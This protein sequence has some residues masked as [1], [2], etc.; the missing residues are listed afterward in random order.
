MAAIGRVGV[1]R[2]GQ[3]INRVDDYVIRGHISNLPCRVL[4]LQDIGREG[5]CIQTI[6]IGAQ[7][8]GI[9][10]GHCTRR[11]LGRSTLNS[12]KGGRRGG[13]G[14]TTGDDACGSHGGIEELIDCIA[15]IIGLILTLAWLVPETELLRYRGEDPED[16]EGAR[17][18]GTFH[19]SLANNE[20]LS[21]S[22][23]G[24]NRGITRACLG[25]CKDLPL[26]QGSL[27]FV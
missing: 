4:K 27:L 16:Q 9:A 5:G 2:S 15:R 1:V 20:G 8:D 25:R 26:G 12:R 7:G 3:R 22:V 18:A 6:K 21:Y 23:V 10:G 19:K 24:N 11:R 17:G 13:R 14:R